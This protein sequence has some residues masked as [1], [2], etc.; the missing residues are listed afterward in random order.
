MLYESSEGH[1]YIQYCAMNRAGCASAQAWDWEDFPLSMLHVAYCA[2][3]HSHQSYERT[4]TQSTLSLSLGNRLC[5]CWIC[6]VLRR[7]RDVLTFYIN[8]LACVSCFCP[9]CCRCPTIS[10]VGSCLRCLFL[11]IHPPVCQKFEGL[12]LQENLDCYTNPCHY[13]LIVW[14]AHVIGEILKRERKET[15]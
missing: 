2:P 6:Q 7:N 14:L 3:L 11:P 9:R 13:R 4:C 10:T 5:V 8:R 15:L 12:C 1:N